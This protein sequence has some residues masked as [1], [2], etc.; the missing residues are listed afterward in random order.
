MCLL[1]FLIY[2]GR[3]VFGIQRISNKLVDEEKAIGL[4][5]FIL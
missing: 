5:C 1:Q 2:A 4:G 3:L